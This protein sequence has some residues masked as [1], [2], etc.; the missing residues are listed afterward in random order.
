M[1]DVPNNTIDWHINLTERHGIEQYPFGN[2]G[3]VSLICEK[4]NGK[5]EEPVVKV[6]SNIPLTVNIYYNG[7]KKVVKV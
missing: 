5:G 2:N 1:A 6:E 4:R 7:N 3:T